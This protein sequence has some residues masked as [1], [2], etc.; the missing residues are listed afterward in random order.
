MFP[1]SLKVCKFVSFSICK[2]VNFFQTKFFRSRCSFRNL[3]VNSQNTSQ[4]VFFLEAKKVYKY[5]IYFLRDFFLKLVTRTCPIQFWEHH[6]TFFAR[7]SKKKCPLGKL[8]WPCRNQFREQKCC[9][10]CTFWAESEL[11]RN[12]GCPDFLDA[13]SIFNLSHLG[14]TVYGIRHR[15]ALLF[16]ISSFMWKR[17][18]DLFVGF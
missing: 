5:I 16:K 2:F 15:F 3:E 6:R 14:T 10:K 12:L 9:Q 18:R 13:F 17:L 7:S 11:P 1:R 8:V 4:K